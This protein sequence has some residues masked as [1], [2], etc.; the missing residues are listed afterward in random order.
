[1]H[2]I[3]L[4][5]LQHYVVCPRQCALIHMEQILKP[6]QAAS[7][8][9]PRPSHPTRVRGLKLAMSSSYMPSIPVAP[10]AGAWIETRDTERR[11]R[12]RTSHPTRVR[13][14]KQRSCSWVSPFFRVAPH[15]GAWIETS[16]AWADVARNTQSHPTRVR[17]LKHGCGPGRLQPDEVA[18]HAGAW[19][20]T[21]I[22]RRR[23]RRCRSRTPRGCV[24]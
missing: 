19:I 7:R 3:L 4:S 22:P 15:A 8:H 16:H 9:T 5:A 24:D 14:L 10:H 2:D 20:E 23:T 21:C 1:M 11:P 17:G 12:R 18:P 13:G 6:E